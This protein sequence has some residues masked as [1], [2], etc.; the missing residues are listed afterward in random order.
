MRSAYI[1]KTRDVWDVEGYYGM[2]WERVTS[3]TTRPEAKERLAEY[4]K[5]D[6]GTPYR[7]VKRR[8]RIEK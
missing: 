6:P 2:G 7:I 1:R 8:E 4:R 5:N 3:E